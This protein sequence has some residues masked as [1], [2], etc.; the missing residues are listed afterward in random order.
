MLEKDAGC[1]CVFQ[2]AEQGVGQTR[3]TLREE[4][5]DG[6]ESGV[7]QRRNGG[8]ILPLDSLGL[9]EGLMQLLRKRDTKKK[10]KKK[11]KP[12]VE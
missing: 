7:T 10:K 6:G 12:T 8:R 1:I 11:L 2:E 4:G 9:Q 3:A 5:V